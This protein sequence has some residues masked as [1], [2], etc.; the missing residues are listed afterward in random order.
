MRSGLQFVERMMGIEPTLSAWEA[1]VLPMNYIRSL[2]KYKQYSTPEGK[3][4][5]PGG[6]F[7]PPLFDAPARRCAAAAEAPRRILQ[8]FH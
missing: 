6:I 3:F 1:G 4:Q 2:Y 7:F 5:S 8:E